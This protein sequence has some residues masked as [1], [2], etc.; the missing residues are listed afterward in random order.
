MVI[1]LNDIFGDS[2][3]PAPEVASPEPAPPVPGPAAALDLDHDAQ[4]EALDFGPDGWPVGSIE[5]GEPCLKCDGLAVWID[6]MGG[7][8]CQTCEAHGLARSQRL[9]DAVARSRQRWP[10][11]PA[12]G[13]APRRG[14]AAPPDPQHLDSQRPRE[15]PPGAFR[16]RET[17]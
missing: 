8:H 1:D 13:T 10:A 16:G 5:P 17:R 6:L 15:W 3:A 14:P 2:T 9:A 4:P 7:R 11:K 12:P